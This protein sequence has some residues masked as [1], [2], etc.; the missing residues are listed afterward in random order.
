[1]SRSRRR[2]P[3]LRPVPLLTAAAAVAVAA[4]TA[5]VLSSPNGS[6]VSLHN[7][8]DSGVPLQAAYQAVSRWGTGYTGQYTIT[9]TGTAPVT[10]WTLSFSLPNGTTVTSLWDG[11]YTDSAGQVTVK[12]A[13]WDATVQPGKAVTV[14]FV[15]ASSGTAGQP[16]NC[17]I[18]GAACLAGGAAA[19][20]RV[21]VHARNA[22]VGGAAA[23]AAADVHV[24]PVEWQRHVP[25]LQVH[26]VLLSRLPS[27][28]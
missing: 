6:R 12:N 5:A 27:V 8:A 7:A 1:M 3:P 13:G 11:T 26:R 10:G 2:R 16:G 25:D 20:G 15:T 28:A 19:V 22:V 9:N 21:H 17:T 18:N 14:G 23:I 4:G 24:D